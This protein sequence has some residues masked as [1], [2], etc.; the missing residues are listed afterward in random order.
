MARVDK[1]ERYR[2]EIPDSATCLE[3]KVSKFF[4][5]LPNNSDLTEEF[6]YTHQPLSSETIN[7]YA[8]SRVPI[9][10]LDDNDDTRK[11]F[12]VVEGPILLVARKGYAG[13]LNVIRDKVC[14]IHEDAY[15]AKT[16]DEYLDKINLDWFC[17][18][19]NFLFQANRTSYFG[20]GDFPR[21]RFNNM[22]VVIPD[23]TIQDEISPLYQRR[24]EVS[25]KL[26]KID[27]L[28]D[29]LIKNTEPEG[30]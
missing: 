23:I 21:E 15:A 22:R 16:K 30:I 6:L 19:Y 17:G 12:K 2:V 26:N 25:F 3:G 13:R 5:V 14:I 24:A 4:D 1:L 28:V 9:G 10:T 11:K 8:T 29:K 20:I 27:A 7:V 18:H